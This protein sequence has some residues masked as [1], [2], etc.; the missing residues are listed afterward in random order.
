MWAG[1]SAQGFVGAP[2]Q[3]HF[4]ELL[5]DG[6]L[7]A[8]FEFEDLSR[9]CGGNLG[10]EPFELCAFHDT[11]AFQVTLSHRIGFHQIIFVTAIVLF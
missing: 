3:C 8:S 11:T 10:L 1:S 4:G 7:N 6:V 2:R 9:R 5:G